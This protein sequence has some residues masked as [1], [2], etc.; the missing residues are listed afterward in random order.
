MVNALRKTHQGRVGVLGCCGLKAAERPGR[1]YNCI[2]KE[3][4]QGNPCFFGY[5]LSG[6]PSAMYKTWFYYQGGVACELSEA[7]NF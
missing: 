7:K 2:N 6:R 5:S 1:G 4:G 3:G